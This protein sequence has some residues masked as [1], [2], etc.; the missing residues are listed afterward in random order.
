MLLPLT[1]LHKHFLF[2]DIIPVT[3]VH[4][5][6]AVHVHVHVVHIVCMYMH[7][8]HSTCCSNS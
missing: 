6:C 5:T 8:Q 7:R 1:S 3:Y 2:T 4:V